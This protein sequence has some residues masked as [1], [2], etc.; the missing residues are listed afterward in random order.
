MNAVDHVKSALTD[1]QS[2][3]AALIE[4][5]ATLES[6]AQA[7]HAIAESQR[8]GGAVYSCG[9]GGSLCDAMHFAEE[10]TGRYR[11]NRPA[12]AATAIADASHMACVANDFGY[13][14]VFSRYIEGVARSGDVLLGISTSGT[15]KNVLRAVEASRAK[16]VKVV[17]LTGR[18][19]SP[20]AKLSDVAI[21][22]PGG[23]YADRV[24][25]LH[26]KCIHI[27]IELVERRLN[28]ENYAGE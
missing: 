7:A 28:P 25:E 11:N 6:I 3:L 10:M 13:E 24:Q 18:A 20:I 4:N 5:E 19:D 14:Y 2:A 12:Y 21:V 15:S 1:A 9:N 27:F 16:G 22:T 17:S 23:R 8:Q 26:I